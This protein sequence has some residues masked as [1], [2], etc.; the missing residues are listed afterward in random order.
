MVT[1]ALRRAAVILLLVLAPCRA[2][3]EAA[4]LDIPHAPR[5]SAA[6]GVLAGG[7]QLAPGEEGTFSL[8]TARENGED[9]RSLGRF[10]G[11]LAGVAMDD[12]GGVLAL[13]ADGALARY[14]D[15]IDPVAPPDSRWN[16]AALFW[17]DG[18]PLAFTNDNGALHAVRVGAD[19]AWTRDERP[20][21]EIG[22]PA[23]VD[24]IR[25]ADGFHLLVASFAEDLSRGAIRH[26]FL[27]AGEGG[28]AWR[29]LPAL[30]VGD[31]AAFAAV[32]AVLPRELFPEAASPGARAGVLAL[33][34]DPVL[35]ERGKTTF[36][37]WRGASWTGLP[38]PEHPAPALESAHAFAAASGEDA[39][40]VSWLLAGPGGAFLVPA[41]NPAASVRV[42][43]NGEGEGGAPAPERWSGLFLLLGIAALSLLACRRSRALSRVF[44]GRPPDLFSR[45]AAL[46]VDWLLVSLLMGGYHVANGDIFILSRLFDLGN[47]EDAQMIFWANLGGLIL[48]TGAFESLFGR[49][50][51][52]HLAALRVRSVPGGRATALQL[53]FRNALR[54]VDMFPLPAGIPGFIGIVATLFGKRRQRVGDRLAGTVVLRHWPLA[55][56]DFLLASASPRRLKLLGA[57]HLSVRTEAME[58]DERIP[59]GEKAADAVCRLSRAKA[60]AA[61]SHVRPGEIVIAADTVVALDGRLLGKPETPE[62]A[63]AMLSG[64]SGRSHTV[65]TGVTVW[66]TLTGQGM[67]DYE[68]TEVEFRVLTDR[69]IEEY[70]ASGEPMDK[71]GGYG[72]Q[73]GFLI[74]QVRG[75]LSNVVGL[76]MEKLRS[77]L[78]ALDS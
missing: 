75:S 74:R 35:R 66:D 62:E 55:K 44:P 28:N 9:L 40:R 1:S 77:M 38:L 42:H 54:V 10:R 24:G 20:V 7:F 41:A 49:T 34:R 2:A 48:F 27:P 18:S 46:A 21:A 13:T 39:G 31:V 52:K 6:A 63:R 68:E 3:R 53:V 43:G 58:V 57:I 37:A 12:G 17:K 51:G 70:V 45:G 30:P 25:L 69:E 61:G 29:E 33:R 5:L 71:A 59:G 65:Y 32:P 19:G 60:Q 47:L 15:D 67:T 23:R 72:V 73:S 50:P 22:F 4:A 64:L 8:F 76:P 78:S 11:L 26:L 56:R 36:H 14:G 16:M